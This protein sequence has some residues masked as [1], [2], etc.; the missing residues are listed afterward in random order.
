MQQGG[1]IKI[2]LFSLLFVGLL[3]FAGPR[4]EAGSQY[5]TVQAGDSLWLIAQRHHTSVNQLKKENNLMGDEIWVGQQLLIPGSGETEPKGQVYT[6]K[7]GDSLFFIARDFGTTI[8]ELKT[9]NNLTGDE[10]WVGQE[11]LI[12]SKGPVQPKPDESQLQ[13]YTVVAGDSLFFI[14]QRFNTTVDLLININGLSDTT[15]Y[16]GQQLKV[17]SRGSSNP[18]PQSEGWDIPAGVA[19]YRVQSGDNLY[20][21]ARKYGSTV[22]AVLKT[23][24]MKKDFITPGQPLFVPINSSEPVYGIAAPKGPKKAGY[25]ELLDWE[26]ANWLFNHDSTGTL[27]DLQS[28]RTFKVTRIGGGNHADLEPLTAQDTAI[29]KEIYGG[30]WSWATRPVILMFEGREIAASM[31]GMPHGFDTVPNNNF[32]GMFCLHFLNSRT[33]NTNQVDPSHRQSVLR[34]AGQ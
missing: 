23:N 6:V 28:G 24:K 22:D 20:S 18:P 12:P 7:P 2:S 19:L 27:N 29:M 4:A 26:Y 34:A 5:Y 17:P 21:I 16:V 8:N 33:H 14:A 1:F 10:I 30:Q 13:N 3:F 11:L 15:I 32:N 25:G 31:N 9:A